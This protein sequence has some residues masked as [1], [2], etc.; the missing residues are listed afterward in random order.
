MRQTAF[1]AFM[2][3]LCAA[4][5]AMA[6]TGQRPAAQAPVAANLRIAP[7]TAIDVAALRD[8]NSALR[9]RL[10]RVTEALERYANCETQR[11][12]AQQAAQNSQAGDSVT[13]A[14]PASLW[15]GTQEA[16]LLLLKNLD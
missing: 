16:N 12:A 11:L 1:V 9:A 14:P 4:G 2:A 3:L 13:I 5:A 8:E 10:D 7:A 15:C 6:Q